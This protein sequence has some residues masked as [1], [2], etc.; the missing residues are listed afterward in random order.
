MR[1]T[2]FQWLSLLLMASL[3]IFA[4]TYKDGHALEWAFGYMIAYG[5]GKMLTIK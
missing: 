1:I 3:C 2:A 4:I 5:I